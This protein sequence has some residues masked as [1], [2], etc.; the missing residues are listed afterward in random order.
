[1][2]ANHSHGKGCVCVL[3][4][5]RTPKR[6]EVRQFEV[7]TDLVG[8][9]GASYTNQ[10]NSKIVA[11]DTQKNTIFLLSQKLNFERSSREDFAI[12]IAR[13]FVRKYPDAV[14]ACTVKIAETVW[15][16]VQVAGAAHH[17]A[18]TKK[19]TFVGHAF[20]K[21]EGS[22]GNVTSVESGV[23]GLTVLK[24]TKYVCRRLVAAFDGQHSQLFHC[25]TGLHSRSS[26]GT[27]T[28]SCLK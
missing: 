20:V 21:A 17:H 9:V 13:H 12:L 6:H 11:T 7:E 5:F 3:R 18:F 14:H 27:S 25:T 1:M 22:R 28:P 4:V 2:L 23:N 24:T 10:D 26:F 16:R 15:E 8:P 19:G